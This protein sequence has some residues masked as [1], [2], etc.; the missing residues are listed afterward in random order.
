MDQKEHPL[1]RAVWWLEHI[2]RHP[3]AYVGKS[4]AKRLNWFQY[5]LIDIYAFLFAI[6]CLFSAFVIKAMLLIFSNNNRDK[7]KID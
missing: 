3:G 2:L 5:N 6:L 1:D 7:I 4:P